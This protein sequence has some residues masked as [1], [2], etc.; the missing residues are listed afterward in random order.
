MGACS[1]PAGTGSTGTGNNRGRA[2]CTHGRM[3]CARGSMSTGVRAITWPRVCGAWPQTDWYSG[4]RPP[5]ARHAPTA[6]MPCAHG[7][8]AIAAR[9]LAC[10]QCGVCGALLSQPCCFAVSSV[11]RL[12]LGMPGNTQ[13]P[14]EMPTQRPQHAMQQLWGQW[15]PLASTR[16]GEAHPPLPVA[17]AIV[18]RS[19][20]VPSGY[21]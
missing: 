2:A 18:V 8:C 9:R 20:C 3:A 13:T 14:P 7:V 19:V 11:A 4:I 16:W 15:A 10:M 21:A 17:T 1:V 5:G 12:R 6:H